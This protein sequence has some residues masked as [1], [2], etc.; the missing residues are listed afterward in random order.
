MKRN[1]IIRIVLAVLSIGLMILLFFTYIQNK[2]HENIKH[3]ID[4]S[5]I[6]KI[7]EHFKDTDMNVIGS[8]I[9]SINYDSVTKE[10]TTKSNDNSIDY[11]VIGKYGNIYQNPIEIKK[12]AITNDKYGDYELFCDDNNRFYY[13]NIQNGKKSKAYKCREGFNN[14]DVIKYKNKD[15]IVSDYIVLYG[16][17]NI[18]LFNYRDGKVT[19]LD[20]KIV[21]VYP[22]IYENDSNIFDSNYINYLVAKNDENKIGL[23]DYNGKV[24]LD[25]EYDSIK[26]YINKDEYVACKDNKCG[27]IDSKGKEI[28]KFEYDN[29]IYSF[30]YKILT[31]GNTAAVMYD[32]KIIIDFILPFDNNGAYDFGS[33]KYVYNDKT[34]MLLLTTCASYD[35]ST[36][37]FWDNSRT[38]LIN[39]KG[40]VRKFDGYLE[41]LHGN[42]NELLY[43]YNIYK[44]NQRYG[45]TFY[46]IDL[47]EYYS[48]N[49]NFNSNYDYSIT[50]DNLSHNKYYYDIKLT[51]NDTVIH[52][53]IDLLNSKKLNEK[54]ANYQYFK[55]GY[56][57]T[58]VDGKLN[59]YKENEVIDSY[60]NITMYLGNYYYVRKTNN[61]YEI[62]ELK[63]NKKDS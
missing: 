22:F 59:I 42:D 35:Y 61:G 45:I 33:L 17:D 34:G 21:E 37:T 57:F 7:T 2:N 16:T 4:T 14:R 46:D 31:R 12:D 50:I 48:T 29:I 39:N 51:Y 27:L 52:T 28:L 53:Y 24:I 15:K 32:N 58:L 5:P 25:F 60:D 44:G 43:L 56:A 49:I 20:S 11:L 41:T 13:L 30:K 1:L 6:P 40:I 3:K 8:Y 26:N 23:I 63:F 36:Q 18:D 38:Y 10:I 9:N 47:Y 19:S 54:K 62:L 55:N